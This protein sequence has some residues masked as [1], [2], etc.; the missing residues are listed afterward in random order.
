MLLNLR[1][2]GSPREL[3][4]SS[5]S[6]TAS[7]SPG[8]EQAPPPLSD[9]A[10]EL[11]RSRERP[12]VRAKRLAAEEALDQAARKADDENKKKIYNHCL[13]A[14]GMIKEELSL[15]HQQQPQKT[16][17]TTTTKI[18]IKL[19]RDWIT[20]ISSSKDHLL[21]ISQSSSGMRFCLIKS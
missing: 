9:N 11:V 13:K 4:G 20:I 1:Y 14:F 6:A 15:R 2:A 10:R 5:P 12:D 17:P 18:T 7:G 8:S 3:S 19:L 16:V 21:R